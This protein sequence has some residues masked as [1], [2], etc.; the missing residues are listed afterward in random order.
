M[1]VKLLFP[2]HFDFERPYLSLPALTA[3]LRQHGIETSQEDVNLAA[4]EYFMRPAYLERCRAKLDTIVASFGRNRARLRD[5]YEHYARSCLAL[6]A[7]P[8]VVEHI[9]EAVKYFRRTDGMLDAEAYALNSRILE[10]AFYLVSAAFYPTSLGRYGFAMAYSSESSA[11]ILAA[12]DDASQNPYDSF[13][14]EYVARELG[15]A[16][17]DLIGISIAASAQIIPGFGL[18]DAIR[19]RMPNTK[20]VLGG[21]TLSQLCEKIGRIPR[22]FRFFDY[23]VQGEGETPLLR[24]CQHLAGEYPLTN[25]PNLLYLDKG[26]LKH[27]GLRSFENVNELPAPDYDGLPLNRYLSPVPVLSLEAARGCYW[28]KCT[29][30]ISRSLQNSYRFRSA[31]KLAADFEHLH[32]RYKM[33]LLVITNEGMPA[34]FFLA[35]AEAILE[36]GLSVPWI[37]NARLQNHFTRQRLERIA[38]SGCAKLCFG[39]ESGSQRILDLMRKG[40]R[41]EEVPGILSACKAA[42]LDVHLFLMIGFPTESEAERTQTRDFV[43]D[44]L[45]AVEKDGFGFHIFVFA[46]VLGA[47]ILEQ[48]PQLGYRLVSKGSRYD[49]EIEFEHRRIGS[50]ATHPSPGDLSQMAQRMTKHINE[51]LCRMSPGVGGYRLLGRMLHAAQP[52]FQA[53]RQATSSSHSAAGFRNGFRFRLNP[54]ITI[55]RLAMSAGGSEPTAK[56][57]PPLKKQWVAYNLH[58]DKYFRLNQPALKFLERARLPKTF[59]ELLRQGS[60]QFRDADQLEK[61]LRLFLRKGIIQA[62]R[63][64][65]APQNLEFTWA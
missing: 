4:L 42:G 53:P 31:E 15:R 9:G 41:L 54:W 50:G 44:Q 38:Q 12:I 47:P 45:E 18:A 37:A 10:E 60:P 17:P 63:M 30:C 58:L 8:L 56:G 6:L 34:S 49:L 55:R 39:L 1:R 14:E 43:V 26:E 5:D 48:L 28:R 16:T 61:V 24:L 40:I 27:T 3:F 13:L 57:L 2:P 19:R 33:G 64:R 32:A 36:R 46:A 52:A 20:I 21:P 11:D 59:D 62:E 29:F 23:L 51:K 25:V 22:L 35:L 65:S 7:A